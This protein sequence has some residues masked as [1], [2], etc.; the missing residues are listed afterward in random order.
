MK[1]I[2]AVFILMV[3][4]GYNAGAQSLQAQNAVLYHTGDPNTLLDSHVDIYN[5]TSGPLNVEVVRAVNNIAT[6]H[7]SY[8]CWGVTCYPPT[9]GS[10]PPETINGGATNSTFI[11]YLQPNGAAGLSTVTYCFYDASNIQD[12]ICLEYVY[13]VTTSGIDEVATNTTFLSDASPNPAGAA[14]KISY[15]ITFPANDVRIVL[16]NMLGATIREIPMDRRNKMFILNT[17]G[18]RS[19]LYFYSLVADNNVV[20]TKK[21]VVSGRE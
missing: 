18:L 6:G 21:L 14:T 20:S 7:L 16:H 12:S 1:K 10:A 17:S 19:G 13:D 4:L 5:A 3:T 11:G 2:Y 8:F 15:N 9:T